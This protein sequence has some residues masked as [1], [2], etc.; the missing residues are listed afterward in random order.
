MFLRF[1]GRAGPIVLVIVSC[2]WTTGTILPF[3]C[4][5]LSPNRDI[6]DVVQALE[7]RETL[8]QSLTPFIDQEINSKGRLR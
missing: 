5:L 4:S 6:R 3:L 2:V 1:G 7:G 8:R